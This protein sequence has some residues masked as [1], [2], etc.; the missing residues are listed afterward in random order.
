MKIVRSTLLLAVACFATI[1]SASAALRGATDPSLAAVLKSYPGANGGGLFGLQ[2]PGVGAGSCPAG[3]KCQG[4]YTWQDFS[5]AVFQWNKANPSQRFLGEASVADNARTLAAYFANIGHETAG[6]T[7]CKERLQLADRS[8]PAAPNTG[9]CSGGFVGSYTSAQS[10]A[11]GFS[12]T[13]CN[14]LKA[15]TAGCT[16]F[17]GNQLADAKDCWFGRGA[18][19]LTW[20]GNYATHAASVKAAGGGDICANPDAVCDSPRTAFVSSLSFWTGKDAAWLRTHAIN[21]A[22]A[23]PNPAD[24]GSNPD[25]IA[26]YDRYIAAMGIS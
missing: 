18:L 11:Q 8:C 3:G 25:R 14:G 7:A 12:V 13:T 21:D 6:Y 15:P 26:D 9:G 5:A 23:I 1:S 19:Q 22:I 20:P 2:A 17:W 24:K 4:F 10:A 16:D